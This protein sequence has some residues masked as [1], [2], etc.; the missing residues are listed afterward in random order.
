MGVKDIGYED[1]DWIHLVW[2]RPSLAKALFE[3]PG[4]VK[5]AWNFLTK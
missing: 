5:R 4:S 3:L 1:V 2:E